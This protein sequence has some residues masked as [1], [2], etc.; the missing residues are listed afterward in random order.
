M[1]KLIIELEEFDIPDGGFIKE[2]CEQAGIAFH[3]HSGICGSCLIHV[4]EGQKNLS[5]LTREELDLGLN[6]DRRLAC[7][8]RI[9]QGAAKI[10]YGD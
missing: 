5:P 2:S 3:C 7:Q 10:S 6:D 4:V 9:L 8:C 1:A